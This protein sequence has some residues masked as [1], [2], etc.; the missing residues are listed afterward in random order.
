MKTKKNTEPNI[1]FGKLDTNPEH[2]LNDKEKMNAVIEKVREELTRKFPGV[3]VRFDSEQNVVQTY[4]NGAKLEDYNLGEKFVRGALK[5]IG[6]WLKHTGA[7]YASDLEVS[8]P[9]EVEAGDIYEIE[10]L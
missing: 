7:G 6:I 5:K 10:K 2:L 1:D 8:V 4:T 3:L 9:G